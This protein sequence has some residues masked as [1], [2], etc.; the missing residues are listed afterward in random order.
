MS[1]IL[2]FCWSDFAFSSCILFM[3]M[4]AM[5][6]GQMRDDSSLSPRD[7]LQRQPQILT[8]WFLFKMCEFL[9]K[10]IYKILYFLNAMISLSV[11]LICCGQWMHSPAAWFTCPVLV[12]MLVFPW[13]CQQ[14]FWVFFF[15]LQSQICCVQKSCHIT[16][17]QSCESLGCLTSRTT[18]NPFKC[19][20]SEEGAQ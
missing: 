7:D 10:L 3:K 16:E 4:W 19:P 6:V 9:L 17:E 14:C 5:P 11:G 1:W 18:Q 2:T 20:W 15:P 13:S 12:R 8:A